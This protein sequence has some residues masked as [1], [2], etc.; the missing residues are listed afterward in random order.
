VVAGKVNVIN[1][2]IDFSEFTEISASSILSELD[3]VNRKFLLSVGRLVERKGVLEF[4]KFV[5]PELKTQSPDTL[6]LVVGD[7]PGRKTRKKQGLI[8]EIKSEIERLGLSNNAMLLGE[9]P[10]EDLLYLYNHCSMFIF[11]GIAVK[12]DMEGFGIVLL[13]ANAAG[14]PVVASNIG[15]VPDAVVDGES[16]FLVEPGNWN[17]F[18]Y[19]IEKLNSQEVLKRRLGDYG[20]KRVKSQFDWPVV[21]SKYYDVI[22][23]VHSRFL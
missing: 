9:I 21:I 10:R 4:I 13:E 2:G 5:M 17:Q 18:L 19:T 20:R 7:E 8:D 16:G 6:L 22:T 1:P 23:Q 12:G 14:K 11:P 3:I 15:G